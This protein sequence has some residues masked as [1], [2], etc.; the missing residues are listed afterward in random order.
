MKQTIKTI[1][2]PKGY[3]SPKYKL[4]DLIVYREIYMDDEIQYTQATIIKA[5]GNIFED[6][7]KIIWF[8]NTDTD[9]ELI[10]EEFIIEKLN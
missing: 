9:E 8:Y 10:E 7:A 3:E 2:K 1:E 6:G 5:E 4:G